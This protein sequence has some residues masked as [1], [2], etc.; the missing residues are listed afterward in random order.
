MC[1][2]AE[3]YQISQTVITT[4]M[5]FL[6]GAKKEYFEQYV[7]GGELV[8]TLEKNTDAVIMRAL[9]NLRSNLMLN[10]SKT[11]QPVR[12]DMKNIDRQG[13]YMEDVKALFKNGVNIVKAN[14][15]V[16]KYLLKLLWHREFGIADNFI[17]GNSE[18]ELLAVLSHEIGHLKHKKNWR[19][20]IQYGIDAVV[21]A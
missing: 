3:D 1:K 5:A 8:P 11:E 6:T 14:Y 18:R 16:N 20:F 10:F 15:T 21:I 9:C 17:D 2:T 19:N 7:T 4:A 12:Y 13:M